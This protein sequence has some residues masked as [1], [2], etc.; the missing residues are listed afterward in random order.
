MCIVERKTHLHANDRRE[1]I[2]MTYRCHRAR[3]SSLCDHVE[4]RNNEQALIVERRPHTD[5][6]S[7]DG[8]LVTEGRDGRE[9]VYRE[10]ARR[11]SKRANNTVR[12]SNTNT[13]QSSVEVPS[14]VGVP[15]SASSTYSYTETRP[16]APSP[17]LISTRLPALDR[18]HRFRSG[19]SAM[20]RVV[21]P[22]GS[23][24]YDRPP[25]LDFPRAT[26]NE[27]HAR[28]S[29]DI[30]HPYS[31]SSRRRPSVR[32]DT[33]A[34]PAMS[35][36][37]STS[38]PG[39]SQLPKIGHS[40]FDSATDVPGY[41][42]RL[43]RHGSLRPQQVEDDRQAQLERGRIAESERRQQARRDAAEREA[44]RERRERHRRDAADAL[45]GRRRQAGADFRDET[46]EAEL[47]QMAR[48]RAAAE[49]RDL[50]ADQAALYTQNRLHRDEDAR[51][52]YHRTR[53]DRGVPP[54]RWPTR[55]EAQDTPYSP[56]PPS[57]RSQ[58]PTQAAHPTSHRRVVIHQYHY[59]S[60]QPTNTPAARSADASTAHE[61]ARAGMAGRAQRATDRLGDALADMHEDP[62]NESAEGECEREDYCTSESS[63]VRDGRRA[64]RDVGRAERKRDFWAR[65]DRYM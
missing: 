48:E 18:E 12:R 32:I 58:Q 19:V 61:Q 51:A 43:S 1:T 46:L 63:R 25:S 57:T 22:D 39:L 45:E 56:S 53:P 8:Y 35:V 31:E 36:S 20:S 34:R 42:P 3:G 29:E 4:H 6:A 40:R 30:D 44:S 27:R 65:G 60:P 23:A 26:E 9:T 16:S 47:A 52:R 38:S 54:P 24:I 62:Y 14:S 50:A 15:S 64:A 11:S 49:L 37:P 21:A 13:D 33:A 41:P 10:V 28:F 7:A 55:A 17:P 59:P 5:H 2:E